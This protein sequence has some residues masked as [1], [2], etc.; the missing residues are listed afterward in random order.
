MDHAA[1]QE[2]EPAAV[3][4]DAA[5][6]AAA[7]DACELELQRRLGEREVVGAPLQRRVR[8][9]ERSREVLE[10]ALEVAHRDPLVDA[11]PLDLVEHR[12][13]G[14]VV[15]AAK[16][17]AGNDHPLR[18]AANEHAADLHRRGV[19]PEQPRIVDVE[20]VLRVAGRVSGR[21]VDQG[22]VVAVVFDLG[23]V[24]GLEAEL[25]EDPPHLPG[26]ERHRAEAAAAQWRRR[27]GEIE[28]LGLEAPSPMRALDGPLALVEGIA[29][30]LDEL[31]DHLT[32]LAASVRVGDLARG[33]A[34][35][36]QLAVAPSEVPGPHRV[37]GGE[38]R[39]GGDCL[40]GF[41]RHAVE[42]GGHALV[43]APRATSTSC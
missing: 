28:R 3:L 38:V 26:G 13:V 31:V 36:S 10:G 5:A 39:R 20:G 32:H 33:R 24:D 9:E 1:A 22:E 37:E 34:E 27:A 17:F 6:G 25:A 43:R 35:T 11:E 42:V 7:D 15:V 2:F 12:H 21:L 41:R 29:D 16:R 8:A 40:E 30:A 23:P 19:G 14:G 18:R 4:A